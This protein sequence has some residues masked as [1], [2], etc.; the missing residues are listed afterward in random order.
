M[1]AETD[2]CAPDDGRILI[3]L[4]P[5]GSQVHTS[6]AEARKAP[7]KLRAPGAVA[8]HQNDDRGKAPAST[9]RLPHADLLLQILHRVD[10]DVEVLVLGPT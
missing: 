6:R 8:S 5:T 9:T 4:E 3:G 7:G 2:V 10:D 1:E